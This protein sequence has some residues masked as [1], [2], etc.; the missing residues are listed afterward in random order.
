[1][2]VPALQN[3]IQTDREKQLY[4]WAI[5]ANGGAT[6]TGTV[7]PL[8]DLSQIGKNEGIWLDAAYGWSAVLH[9]E[10]QRELRGMELADSI[11]LDPHKWFGQTFETGCLLVRDGRRLGQTFSLKP[12]YLQDVLPTEMEINFADHGI[13]L[14]RRF[15]ALRIWLSIKVL[16]LDWFK[17]LIQRGIDLATL[18]A[19]LIEDNPH[20]EL[21]SPRKLS[22]VC[23][24]YRPSSTASEDEIESLNQNLIRAIRTAGLFFLSSTRLD[25]KL[26]LR[27]C[28]VNWR[29]TAQ[30]V[31]AIL[32]WI[33]DQGSNFAP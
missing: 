9:P 14:T 4:P 18:A 29:T 20:F 25:G 6:N 13:A 33:S 23:F 3:Q 15:R 22:V 17:S 26:S 2:S 21:L 27:F 19:H 8:E 1:M 7:D 32:D 10:G 11:T 16:G 12:E 28:F 30:D 24:R 5:L 31:E